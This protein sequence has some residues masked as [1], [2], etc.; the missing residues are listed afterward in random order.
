MIVGI[1]FSIFLSQYEIGIFNENGKSREAIKL[2]CARTLRGR[3]CIVMTARALAFNCRSTFDN[4][5]W[6]E[7]TLGAFIHHELSFTTQ[8]L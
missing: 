3:R 5:G 6:A 8:M 4:D 1:I 2:H 7:K